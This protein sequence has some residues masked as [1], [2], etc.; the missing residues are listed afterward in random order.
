MPLWFEI[1]VIVLLAIV[2][3]SLIDMCFALEG[4]TLYEKGP[5]W[6][7]GFF[8]FTLYHACQYEYANDGPLL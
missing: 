8:C 4:V 6:H 2:A 5:D 7:P 1:T 3:V